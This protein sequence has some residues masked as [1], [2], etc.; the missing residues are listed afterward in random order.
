MR[1]GEERKK[2]VQNSVFTDV[3]WAIILS[4]E[5]L[6]DVCLFFSNEKKMHVH[7]IL[8]IEIQSLMLDAAALGPTLTGYEA[9]LRWLEQCSEV[10]AVFT[11]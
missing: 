3:L 4:A 1:E 9:L 2:N 11:Q 8:Q 6:I 10:I 7:S 5:V